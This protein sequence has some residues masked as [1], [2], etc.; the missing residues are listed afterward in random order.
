MKLFLYTIFF[1]AVILAVS[2]FLVFEYGSSVPLAGVHHFK[3]DIA[4]VDGKDV[5]SVDG[6]L[7]TG[8]RRER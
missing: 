4:R 5:V 7:G 2:F 1:V 8:W 6:A 3:L